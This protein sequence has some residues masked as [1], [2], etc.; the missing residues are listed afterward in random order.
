M[1]ALLPLTGVVLLSACGLGD[2]ATAAAVG[3]KSK[4][5][6]IEQA[7]ATQQHVVSEID[8]ANQQARERL[9]AA[10]SR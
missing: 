3:A 8:K 7:K 9:D 2:T 10:E 1:K 6:E 5:I 4:A